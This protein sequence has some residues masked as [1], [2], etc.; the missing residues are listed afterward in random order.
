MTAID[1]AEDSER[2]YA[3]HGCSCMTM[4]GI[5]LG[6]SCCQLHRKARGWA[7]LSQHG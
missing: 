3:N 6:R 5:I 4:Q 7:R 2:L 1:A